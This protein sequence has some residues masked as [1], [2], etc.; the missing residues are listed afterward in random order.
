VHGAL[1]LSPCRV[2]FK[3][4]D[5][6]TAKQEEITNGES[7]DTNSSKICPFNN[8]FMC[9]LN[10][11][12]WWGLLPGNPAPQCIPVQSTYNLNTYNIPCEVQEK[13][14]S[15][16]YTDCDTCIGSN[17][18]YWCAGQY[19]DI[20]G[21]VYNWGFCLANSTYF[22]FANCT[23]KSGTI[24][25]TCGTTSDVPPTVT[26]PPQQEL[27]SMA[28]PYEDSCT[29]FTTCI[30]CMNNGCGWCSNTLAKTIWGE[31]RSI[32]HKKKR[33]VWG[34]VLPTRAGVLACVRLRAH[35][36]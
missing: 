20:D 16:L 2:V 21:K 7:V 31:C 33:R 22:D 15:C 17:S 25:N 10:T 11:E 24:T 23:K 36:V 3:F 6:V 19:M 29:A 4:G 28:N 32:F 5:T 12:C 34:A 9:S 35:V 30:T 18:C 8:C 26:P 27:A 1:D 13:P 14:S